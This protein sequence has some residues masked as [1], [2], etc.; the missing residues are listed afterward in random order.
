MKRFLIFVGLIL[1]IIFVVLS[2]LYIVDESNKL[3]VIYQGDNLIP[4]GTME[5]V[6]KEAAGLLNPTSWAF[7]GILVLIYLKILWKLV[8]FNWKAKNNYKKKDSKMRVRQRF[9]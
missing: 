9:N 7:L 4:L 8:G 3:W 2:Y 1:L 5:R 6:P